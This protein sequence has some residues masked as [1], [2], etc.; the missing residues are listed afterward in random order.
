MS[1]YMPNFYPTKVG[2]RN[3]KHA[4]A[5]EVGRGVLFFLYLFFLTLLTRG[6]LYLFHLPKTE[7]GGGG[8][9]L[10]YP[11]MATG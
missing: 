11:C 8:E 10:L 3:T 2:R 5:V 9:V 1:Y 7:F 4:R 6:A